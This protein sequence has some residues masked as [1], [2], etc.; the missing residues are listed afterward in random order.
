MPRP[1]SFHPLRI[2]RL[3]ALSLA[4]GSNG[5]NQLPV[6]QVD[7][8]DGAPID[9]WNSAA[10]GPLPVFVTHPLGQDPCWPSPGPCPSVCTGAPATCPADSCRALAID[11][12]SQLSTFLNPL[13]SAPSYDSTCSVLRSPPIPGLANTE[14][15]LR[16]HDFHA[17][18]LPEAQAS[19]QRWM[20]DDQR[21]LAGVLGG[22][23]LLQFAA[24]FE[25]K[26]P[27]QPVRARFFR[28]LPG[29]QSRLANQGLSYLAAQSPGQFLGRVPGDQ[30]ELAPG[31]DC[32]RPIAQLGNLETQKVMPPSRLQLDVCMAP[33]PCALVATSNESCELRA[34][35]EIQGGCQPW[36]QSLAS[37]ASLLLATA[38]P[39][40]VLF[41]DSASRILPALHT[42]PLCSRYPDVEPGQPPPPPFCKKLDANGTL[43][44]PG[45]APLT[46]LAT[47]KV[48]SL[49]VLS[50]EKSQYSAHPCERWQQRMTAL[51]EQCKIFR[52]NAYRAYPHEAVNRTPQ[53][54]VS[55]ARPMFQTGAVVPGSEN[56]HRTENWLTITVV[57]ASAPMV[58]NFRRSSGTIAAQ[59]D[60]LLGMAAFN[61]TRLYL[62]FTESE[63]SPGIR[64]KCL[65]PQEGTC[66]ALPPC[67]PDDGQGTPSCCFGMPQFLIEAAIKAAPP[68]QSPHP[69]C[70]ALSESAKQRLDAT[71]PERCQPSED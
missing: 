48:Q 38:V 42:L 8:V 70:A 45:W 35:P 60:G 22:D 7:Q 32:E 11:S 23:F 5:C 9:A 40:I 56:N 63:Q 12:L 62:D 52:K 20:L 51:A 54:S 16:I 37:G 19:A 58:R 1:L 3:V 34:T 55:L 53:L 15:R 41:S 47:Y 43:R 26:G 13:K 30:C 44:L 57:P 14:V 68:D 6:L 46:G 61:Q 18:E 2:A 28:R 17:L 39:G 24:E 4:L 29:S 67:A 71:A 66:R 10:S 31:L 21:H 59:A 27:G 36:N 50:G 64:V 65:E 25:L 49:A 33:P 69:C